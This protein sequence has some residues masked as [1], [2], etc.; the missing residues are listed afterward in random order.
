MTQILVLRASASGAASV[1]N[2]LIDGYLADL[3]AADP[4]VAIRERDLDTDPIPHITAQTLA[5]IGRPAPETAAAIPTRALSDT[6]LAE[7]LAADVLVIGAPMYNFGLPTPL[8]SW[9]DHVLR[10]GTTFG[11]T[12]QGP[13]GLLKGK[14]AVAVATRGGFYSAPPAAA[15][16]HS[17]PHLLALLGF[18][19]ITEVET[20]IAEGLATGEENAAR[21]IAAATLALHDLALHDLALHDL[22]LRD[23]APLN[24]V[25]A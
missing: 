2:R 21:A 17:L 14:R 5:G 22:A 11:Y 15:A 10:A 16:D 19:G 12:A 8:K 9:F 4:A 20:I 24:P 13:E 18:M 7:L 25:P 1:S 3:R 23:P 6:L